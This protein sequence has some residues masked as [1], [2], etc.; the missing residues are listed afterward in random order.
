[1]AIFPQAPGGY[2]LPS[3]W[4]T[5]YLQETPRAHTKAHYLLHGLG[6]SPNS[7]VY[8][9]RAPQQVAPP[10]PRILPWEGLT[11][12]QRP[13]TSLLKQMTPV[14]MHP[15][16]CTFLPPRAWPLPRRTRPWPHRRI[17]SWI[18]RPLGSYQTLRPGVAGLTSGLLFGVTAR[19]RPEEQAPKAQCLRRCRPPSP[20]L[21]SS[22]YRDSRASALNGLWGH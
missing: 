13:P 10:R 14:R 18:R 8:R 5:R 2:F 19:W 16:P 11:F 15:V 21:S 6:H 20:A 7:C 12:Q 3:P 1:M 4:W 22:S 9:S 17:R